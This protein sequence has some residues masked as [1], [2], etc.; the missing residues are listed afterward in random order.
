MNFQRL[1]E[2]GKGWRLLP[3]EMTLLLYSLFCL[4]VS[5]M[6]VQFLWVSFT[7]A[8]LIYFQIPATWHPLSITNIS[9][10]WQYW[11]ESKLFM[12][13]TSVP[14]ILLYAGLVLSR[15]LVKNHSYTYKERLFLNW[16]SFILI[17]SFIGGIMA[18]VFIYDGLGV[19]IQ[20]M[21]PGIIR[22]IFL[23]IPF[24]IFISTSKIWAKH[25]LKSA[26]STR[27][28]NRTQLRSRYLQIIFTLPL[29][30]SVIFLILYS[31]LQNKWYFG[32]TVA[33]FSLMI[34]FIITNRFFHEKVMLSKTD[35]ASPQSITILIILMFL[36]LIA[37]VSPFVSFQLG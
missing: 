30:I 4:I 34:P 29:L 23:L 9:K 7:S 16:L 22:L 28:I 33:S 31:F 24:I 26:P 35:T 13:Y 11:N 3:E 12:I 32:I 21:F 2:T 6:L 20:F 17:N 27:M 14:L 25:F 1:R 36:I 18:G 8:L 5:L 37:A 15:R 10:N 19:V